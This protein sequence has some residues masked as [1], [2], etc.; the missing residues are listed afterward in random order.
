M[1]KAYYVATNGNDSNPGTIDRPWRTIHKAAYTLKAGEGVLIR[2]GQY[3]ISS[4]IIPSNSGSPNKYI[5][6]RAYLNEEVVIRGN[7]STSTGILLKGKSYISFERLT[8]RNFQQGI[9]CLAPG[10]HIIIRDCIFEYLSL[11]HI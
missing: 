1:S 3:D 9:N 8:V 7:G 5:V 10:H 4:P 6:Y 2:G 11:I